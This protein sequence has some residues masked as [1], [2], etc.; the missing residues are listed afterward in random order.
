MRVIV[1]V[2]HRVSSMLFTCIKILFYPV[3][4]SS[5]ARILNFCSPVCSVLYLR[6]RRHAAES[7]LRGMHSLQDSSSSGGLLGD[8]TKTVV[9][10]NAIATARR[11]SATLELLGIAAK[12]L[13]AEMQQRQRLKVTLINMDQ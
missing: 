12:P 3:R 13:H 7:L 9:F 11:V 5:C 4:R 1:Q 6:R 2:R 8:G 10:V